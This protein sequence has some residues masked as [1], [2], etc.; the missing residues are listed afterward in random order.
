[1]LNYRYVIYDTKHLYFTYKLEQVTPLS[2]QQYGVVPFLV[3]GIYG[4]PIGAVMLRN[5]SAVTVLD[6]VSL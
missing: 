5:T 3:P 1:M 6:Y 4:S 2:R